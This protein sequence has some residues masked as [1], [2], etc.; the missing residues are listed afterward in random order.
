MKVLMLT[1]YVTI[2]S[3]KEFSRNKTGFGYMVY[4]IAKG[5]ATKSHVEVLASYTRGAEFIIDNILFLKRSFGLF[6][7][8]I[9]HV[10]SF[11]LVFRL[12]K[13]YHMQFPTLIRL[14]YFW[15]ISGYYYDVVEKGNYDIVHI[16]GC[17]FETELWMHVCKKAHQRYIVTLH[18]LDSF[19]DSINLEKAGKQYERDFLN[20]V[21]K[22]DIIISVI[23]TGIK[24]TIEETY[25]KYNCSNIKVVCNSF[26]ELTQTNL[27]NVRAKYNIP[28]EAKVILY[29]GNISKNKNQKQ[30]IEAFSLLPEKTRQE[31]YVLFCGKKP[32]SQDSFY[33]VL[34]KSNSAEHLIVCGSIDKENMPNYYQTANGVALLSIREGFGLSII[35]GMHYGIPSMMFSDMDAFSDIYDDKAVIDILNRQNDTVADC[36]IQLLNN[37][38]NKKTIKDSSKK[39]SSDT[40]ANNYIRVYEDIIEGNL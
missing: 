5:V 23:S 14:I 22:G 16:H 11:I 1:P 39:F 13:K 37:K 15:L 17:S 20:R 7:L 34:E 40:M 25:Q 36:I 29:V 6:L 9:H 26:G 21:V 38:W 8:N 32:E 24:K 28:E 18:G 19:S 4:D 3:K 10:I 31:T 33:Q 12:W 35:E 30:K 2:T 27:I